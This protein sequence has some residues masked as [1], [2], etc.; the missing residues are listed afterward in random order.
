MIMFVLL[1]V[2]INAFAEQVPS[3]IKNNAG[4]WADGTIDDNTFLQGIQFLVKTKIIKSTDTMS[5]DSTPPSEQKSELHTLFEI[6]AS[7]KENLKNYKTIVSTSGRQSADYQPILPHLNGNTSIQDCMSKALTD[8]NTISSVEKTVCERRNR[9]YADGGYTRDESGTILHKLGHP[10]YAGNYDSSYYTTPRSYDS[11]SS[12]PDYDYPDYPSSN[13]GYSNADTQKYL[14]RADYYANQWIND[15]TPYAE[16]Y[17]NG[18][19]SYSEYERMGMQ[20]FDYYSNQ[21][22]NEFVN[23]L[24]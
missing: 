18:Q 15:I 11:P 24:D 13:Y 23:D 16:Q 10:D 21:F 9:T 5:N 12:Y 4:W 6:N 2:P 17:V 8:D 1:L 22:A 19:M 14:D 20:S 7:P 3:W